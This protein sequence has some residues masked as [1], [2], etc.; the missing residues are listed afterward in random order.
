MTFFYTDTH[1]QKKINLLT[2]T[3]SWIGRYGLQ[4]A[5]VPMAHAQWDK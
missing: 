1:T 4:K 5:A 2:K 3:G